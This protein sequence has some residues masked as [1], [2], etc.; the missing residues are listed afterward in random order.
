MRSQ[1]S[2]RVLAAAGLLT[3][4]AA[5]AVWE[6]GGVSPRNRPPTAP[7]ADDAPIPVLALTDVTAGSGFEFTYENGREAGHKAIL[8]SLGGG[9]ATFDYDGDGRLDLFCPGGGA[10]GMDGSTGLPS[11]GPLPSALFRNLGGWKFQCVTA[12]SGVGPAQV[13]SHGCCA[14]DYDSDGFTDVLVTGYGGLLLF[15]NQ[16]DGRF[17]EVHV[18]AGLLDSSWSTSAAW[19]DLDGNGHLDLYVAHYVDWSFADGH[20]PACPGVNHEHRDY[21]SPREFNP[22]PHIVYYGNGDGTFRDA[23]DTAG[24]VVD[25]L[26]C[27]KGL[28]VVLGD[29]DL[30]GDLDIFVANDT[31][32]NFLYLNRHDGV[33]D[34]VGLMH[35]VGTDAAGKRT[36]NMGVDLGDFNGDG[37]PDIWVSEYENE[38]FSLYR[39]QGSARFL[40]ASDAAGIN[41]L[42]RLYVGFGTAFCDVDRDGDEDFVVSNG[43][44]IDFPHLAPVKQEPLLLIN[45]DLHLV[46]AEF[47]AGGYFSTPH[48]GRGLAVSDLDDDGD[49]DFAFSHNDGEPN[50]LVANMI[51]ND[52]GWLRVRLIGVVSNRDAIG[53]RLVLHTSAGDQ[54]R[55]VKGGGSYLSQ[56]DLRP[57]WGVRAGVE[58]RSLTIHWPSG[59][60]QEVYGFA[61]NQTLV[62]V[63]PAGSEALAGR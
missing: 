62:I 20:H 36:G 15:R 40:H 26:A 33:F 10:F 14:A 54:L 63:E 12:T 38:S 59:Q 51:E 22:V 2:S 31:E 5:G 48:R 28:G 57:F 13:Y 27:G 9:V 45:E 21:C 7:A 60:V 56:S 25:P 29:V 43:H 52:N 53:A 6:C 61:A 18:Q 39:N 19:G 17:A 16:G 49:L 35:G 44:V 58:I 3:L 50:A 11:V 42:G 4:G 32:L 8:E 23:T 47:S 41:S 1:R 30:D 46:K 24:L 34:E 55:L 37:L